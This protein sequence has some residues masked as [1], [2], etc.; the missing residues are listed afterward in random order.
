MH[1]ENIVYIVKLGY[2]YIPTQC[3]KLYDYSHIFT[4]ILQRKKIY[5]IAH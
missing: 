1:V 2:T 5:F 4:S 3:N